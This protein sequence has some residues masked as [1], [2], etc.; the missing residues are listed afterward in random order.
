MGSSNLSDLVE[1]AF[2]PKRTIMNIFV[3]SLS[4]KTTEEELQREFESFGEVDSVKIILD[5]ETLKSRGFAFVTMPNQ[6]QA[7]AAIAGLN[8]KELNGFALKIN[9]ARPR[10]SRGGPGR[11]RSEAGKGSSN[12]SGSGYG[13]GSGSAGNGYT[14][15]RPGGAN[16]DKDSDIYDTKA[17]PSGGGYGRKG[18]G[19]GSHGSGGRSGGGRRSY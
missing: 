14:R 18:R 2:I 9:E 4:F 19:G 15:G 8:G 10:E 1:T 13:F 6:D 5:H 17:G 12:R 11:E 16:N 7:T 3:G